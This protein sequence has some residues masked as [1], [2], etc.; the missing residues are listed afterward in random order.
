MR[1]QH[2]KDVY[3]VQIC[4]F[5][6]LRCVFLWQNDPQRPARAV[7]Q[8]LGLTRICDAGKAVMSVAIQRDSARRSYK[9]IAALAGGW[10]A[11]T[12]GQNAFLS[13]IGA[14]AAR[15][16]DPKFAAEWLGRSG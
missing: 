15:H 5:I 8:N 2:E 16:K 10:D 12:Q 1:R 4:I 7:P 6:V 11:P 3:G 9:R 13:R 14:N